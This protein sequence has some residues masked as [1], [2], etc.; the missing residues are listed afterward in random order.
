[1][2]TESNTTTTTNSNA[3]RGGGGGRGRSR[4]RGSGRSGSNK[5]NNNKTTSDFRGHTKEMNGHVFECF[6]EGTK[7][8]QFTKSLEALSKYIAKNIKNPKDMMSITEELKT[9]T[10]TVP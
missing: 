5:N 6:H 3:G 8:N 4:G 9:P 10:V 1:M 7:Q 2:S